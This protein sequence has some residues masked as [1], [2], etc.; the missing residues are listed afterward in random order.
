MRR[1][2][3]LLLGLAA[4]GAPTEPVRPLL[5]FSSTIIFGIPTI[6]TRVQAHPDGIKVSGVITTPSAEYTL[7]GKVTADG[8]KLRL[9]INVYNNRQ[10]APFRVQNYYEGIISNLT[11]GDYDLLVIH[12]LHYDTTT[13]EQAFH[14]AI[15]IP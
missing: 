7:F 8:S 5:A 1:A 3:F 15:H 9:E 11:P 2:A 4:C 6:A 14:E 10:G 13:S 12:T